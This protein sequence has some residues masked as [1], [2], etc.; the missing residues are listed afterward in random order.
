MIEK[1]HISVLFF[2]LNYNDIK[3]GGDSLALDKLDYSVLDNLSPEEKK[4]ALSILQEYATKGKSEQLDE[5]ISADYEEIPV[6]IEEFLHN[7]DYLGS[8]LTDDEGRFTVFPYWVNLLK[9]IFPDSY[10]TRYNMLVLSGAI[11]LGKSFVAVICMLYMLY[12]ML[13]LKDPYKHFGLQPIDHITFSI[14]NIT[15]DAAK[16][17]A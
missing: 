5:L 17:V 14:M 12:R 4:L 3:V 2:M 11:G 6:V 15:L 7:P 9:E 8:G 16:G 1:E 10:S 13:C